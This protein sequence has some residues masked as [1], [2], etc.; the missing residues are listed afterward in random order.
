MSTNAPER[1]CVNHGNNILDESSGQEDD[2]SSYKDELFML[3][4]FDWNRILGFMKLF[5][6]YDCGGHGA[7]LDRHKRQKPTISVAGYLA[8]AGQWWELDRLWTKRLQ[9]DGF[10][11]FHMTD[12]MANK[13][14]TVFEK[15]K[16]WDEDRKVAFLSDLSNIILGN[17]TGAIGM[18]VYRADYDRVLADEPDVMQR[19]LGGPFS[20]CAFRCFE[21]GVDWSLKHRSREAI[22]YIFEQGDP[23]ADQVYETHKLFSDVRALGR[24][25]WIGSLT[26]AAKSDSSL[27]AA[28]LLTWALN[29]ELYHQLYPEPEYEFLRPTLTNLLGGVENIYKGY[30]EED[31]R[32]RDGSLLRAV[33]GMTPSTI[34]AR[35]P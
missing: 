20:F 18:A 19:A 32:G 25:Y 15:C 29:R 8:T 22:N 10:R 1:V 14:G 28:D 11:D 34:L 33:K 35:I 13:K 17:V 24:R 4:R 26:F 3:A 30:Y 5:G 27:Q 12:F 7:G 23:G 9:K 6:Y 31:L 16:S 2:R 21:S